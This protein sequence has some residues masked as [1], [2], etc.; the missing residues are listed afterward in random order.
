MKMTGEALATPDKSLIYCD[1]PKVGCTHWKR[2]LR[3]ITH[4]YEGHVDNPEEIPRIYAHFGPWKNTNIIKLNNAT[5]LE[6]V[7]RSGLK[8]MFS[9]DPYER[10]WS[11][12][13]DK[14]YLPDFWWWLGTKMISELRPSADDLS[15]K[16]GHDVTFSEF[17][18][19]TAVHLKQGKHID[20][21]F[22]P[23]HRRCNP[24]KMNFNVVGKM[25]T[26]PSDSKL[27][28]DNVK[29]KL[30]SKR[31]VENDHAADEIK[32]LTRYNFDIQTRLTDLGKREDCYNQVEIAY[33]LW[34]TFQF[35]GYLGDEEEFPEEEFTNIENRDLIK[36]TLLKKLLEIRKQ[37]SKEVLKQWKVQRQKYLEKAYENIPVYILEAVRDE[38]AMDFEL[39]QYNKE[40]SYVFQKKVV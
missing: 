15:K 20:I 21:H 29:L 17:L 6:E 40:P 19:F 38:Y 30:R 8:F 32:M 27:I 3:F 22:E 34:K 1:V 35:N 24:C 10:L 14:L 26:F 12:Y 11:G 13:L 23:M 37:K 33:R 4:D 5:S 36:E 2:V 18:E 31:S 7:N 9:R 28:M 16:C 25:E 39:F